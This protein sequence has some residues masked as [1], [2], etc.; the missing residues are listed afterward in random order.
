MGVRASSFLSRGS[1]TASG[2][3]WYFGYCGYH[4]MDDEID[5]DGD[6]VVG[7]GRVVLLGA[8]GAL[9]GGSG[10]DEIGDVGERMLQAWSLLCRF[11]V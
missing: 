5:D 1:K 11:L 2:A 10:V 6:D 7:A 9:G 8:L 3:W 4:E